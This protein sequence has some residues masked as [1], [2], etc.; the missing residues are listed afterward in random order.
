M[1]LEAGKSL[2]SIG[3]AEE[4]SFEFK[5]KDGFS[6]VIVDMKGVGN[7]KWKDRDSKSP[8]VKDKTRAR[9]NIL[10]IIC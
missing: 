4:V 7:S 5:A 9:N 6:E 1:H 8:P 3:R 2:E 10:S